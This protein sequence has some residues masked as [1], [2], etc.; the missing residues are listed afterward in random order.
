MNNL[1][2]FDMK[3]R[4]KEWLSTAIGIT[5]SGVAIVM[6]YNSKIDT[7]TLGVAL[8]L[9]WTYIAAKD[10]LLEGVTGGLFKQKNSE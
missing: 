5:V 7:T 8:S 4:F 2:K 10:S 6:W 3:K 1:N 9:G